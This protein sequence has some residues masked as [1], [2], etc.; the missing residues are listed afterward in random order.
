MDKV[1]HY[2]ISDMLSEGDGISISL[3]ITTEDFPVVEKLEY[4]N[5]GKWI[6]DID[7][8][9]RVYNDTQQQEQWDNFQQR[10]IDF[11]ANDNMRVI[12]DIMVESD[13]YYSD[14]Y[15]LEVVVNSVDIKDE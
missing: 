4:H 8:L 6:E 13:K 15:K 5:A 3:R 14:A 1:V 12:M 11:L 10:L 7:Q 2:S 9:R